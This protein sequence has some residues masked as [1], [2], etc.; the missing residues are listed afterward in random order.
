M[1]ER[2]HITAMTQVIAAEVF[3]IEAAFVTPYK[4]SYGTQATS[5]AV[6]LKLTDADGITGWGEANP[7]YPFTEES[8]DEAAL[9]LKETLLPAV[10]ASSTPEPGC[11][12]AMLDALIPNHLCAKGAVSTALLDLLGRRLGVSVSTLL[13]GALRESIPVLWPLSN[14]TAED[15]IRVIDER[16]AQGFSTFMLKM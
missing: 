9:A 13:G 12:D 7:Y 16:A 4:L 3:V 8:P 6:M 14:G 1:T 5:R 15:D 10:L 2:S 11:I